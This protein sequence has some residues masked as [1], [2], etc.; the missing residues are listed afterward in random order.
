MITDLQPPGPPRR[1]RLG[2][3][4][5]L[6]GGG[7]QLAKLSLLAEEYGDLVFW[8]ANGRTLLLLR[9]PEHVEHVLIGGHDRYVKAAHYRL[10][11]TVTGEGLLTNEGESWANQ[12]R[13]MQPMFAKG[14]L[15]DLA[16]HMSSSIDDFLA[17]WAELGEGAEIEVAEAMS[18]LTLDVVGRALFGTSLGLVADRLRPAVLVGLRTAM[19][20]ARLQSFFTVPP[21]LIDLVGE[22]VFRA[23]VL[24]GPLGRIRQAMRTIDNVVNEVIEARVATGTATDDDLLGL[25]LSATDE[26]GRP[27]NRKQ[28]RDELVTLMLA[29]HETTANGLAWM[30]YLLAE[31]PTARERML[32]EIDTVLARRPPSADD[33]E[34]LPWTLAC[35]H[36]AMRLYP[37]AWI[38]EREAVVDDEIDGYRIP[39]GTTVFI[40]V[41]LI[42]RDPRWWPEPDAFDP[43]RFVDRPPPSRGTYLPFG[44][45]RRVC[46]GAG[47]AHLEAT[48]IAANTAQRFTL[49]LSPRA[50]VTPEATVTLRPRNGIP[51][52]LHPRHE[53]K[54]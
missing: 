49:E 28:V 3:A 27:M 37:P 38:L 46:I 35:F 18:R 8:R 15:N 20:A 25:L 34:R 50:R 39:K 26:Q 40:P 22:A 14:H 32:A 10:L 19:V 4:L 23:P 52:T 21:Q 12:R 47:F 48:L 17:G 16:V 51:M 53:S 45:G 5:G 9:R 31:N 2:A 30:W 13:L 29:G 54:P 11:A 33:D 43:N 41:S 42:H 44:A 1:R 6:L 36:E 7:D 24:P